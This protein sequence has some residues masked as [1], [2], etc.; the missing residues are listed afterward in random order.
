MKSVSKRKPARVANKKR[1]TDKFVYMNES[2]RDYSFADFVAVKSGVRGM[3]LSFG[4]AHP[5]EE[6]LMIFKEIL[7]PLDVAHRLQVIMHDQFEEL[8]EKGLIQ[9]EPQRGAEGKK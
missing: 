9:V 8:I 7:L 2:A 5:H 1:P 4:K 3:L 6:E